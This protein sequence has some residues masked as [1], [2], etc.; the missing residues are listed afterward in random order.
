MKYKILDI[1]PT[2][3]PYARDIELRMDG[4][5][6]IRNQLLGKNGNICDFSNAHLYFGFHRTCDG[7]VYREWAPSAD[8]L[9]LTGDMVNWDTRRLYMNHIGGGVWE[10]YMKG[11]DFLYDGCHVQTIVSKDGRDYRRIPLYIRRVLQDKTNYSWCGVICDE[12]EYKW[13]IDNFKP[14]KKNLFIYECHIGMAQEK[15]DIGTYAEFA[16]NV[17]PRIKELGYNVIQIMAIMEHPYYGSFGYQVSNFFAPCSRYGTPNELK[18]LIDK[19]H[20]MGIAVLLDIVH[21]HAVANEGDGL[22][23]FDGTTSQFFH[24]GTRGDH[25]AWGTKLFN[26]GSGGVLHFLLSNLK[27]WMEEY[28]FDG[29]R[30]DGVTSMIYHN[31]GL[32]VDFIGMDKYFSHNSDI[33]AINY[34]QLANELIHK[35][36]PNAITIA[37]DMSA[38]PGMCIPIKDGGVGFDFRLSMGDPD[39]WIRFIKDKKDEDWDVG[40]MWWELTNRRAGEKYIGYAE[41]H[42]QALVGD[43][44]IMFRLC[45][46]DMYT[47]MSKSNVNANIDR[48]M[49]LHKMIRL[50][51][52][53]VG[54]EGYLNFMGNEFGH[55]EWIDFPREGN[56]W[57]YLYC[58]R[59]WSLTDNKDLK[60]HYLGDFDR[61]MISLAK[62]NKIYA[63]NP[64][65]QRF[66]DAHQIMSYSR[67]ALTFAFNFSPTRADNDFLISVPTPGRYKVVLHTDESVF[68]GYDRISKAYV[69]TANPTGDGR[70]EFKIFLPPRCGLVLKKIK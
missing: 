24:D 9:F 56:G 51:T 5:K 58:R 64:D 59:Q 49:A 55:P 36:N 7:W 50:L 14:D 57:S 44:T 33:E 1:D 46:A 18:A 62:K 30:F 66:D 67:G 17:L 10:V 60:Y 13:Q 35:V 41:S 53:S 65:P 22:N 37:E 11:R 27:Y 15:M 8:A 16:E 45:G 2:L 29:F 52:M 31:H 54:G 69:Y 48:G 43:K 47:D 25:P 3:K 20:S 32:G 68:G 70:G 6:K 26:Y 40:K 34:L 12:P 39:M 19:A 61:E 4:Y 63:K 21:S 42:D 28:R 38:L 23:R